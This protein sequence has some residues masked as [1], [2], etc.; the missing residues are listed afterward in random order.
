M[1]A[2]GTGRTASGSVSGRGFLL[3][4]PESWFEFDVWRATRTGDLARIVDARIAAEPALAPYRAGLLRALR[5]NAAE[6]ERRGAVLGAATVEVEDGQ[7]ALMA[8]LTVFHTVGAEDPELNTVD[9]IA[10]AITT[11]P[12]DAGS[13]HWRRVEV[14]DRPAGRAVQVRGVESATVGEPLECVILQSL[15]PVPA[16]AA[17]PDAANVGNPGVLNVVLTSPMTD[18]A[19]PMLD[20][21]DAIAGTLAWTDAGTPATAGHQP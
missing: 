11:S 21:F 2:D 10:A 17:N 6:A 14:V 5:G 13:G 18:V 12:P 4:V 1:T 8:S 20:L 15:I 3:R 16:D 19:E 9:A 7:V